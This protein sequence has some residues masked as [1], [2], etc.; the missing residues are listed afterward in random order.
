MGNQ[1]SSGIIKRR[2][3]PPQYRIQQKDH[4]RRIYWKVTDQNWMNEALFLLNL[5]ISRISSS[6]ITIPTTIGSLAV[7]IF[8][9]CLL[10]KHTIFFTFPLILF[11]ISS[12]LFVSLSPSH[13]HWRKWRSE[14]KDGERGPSSSS[15][16]FTQKR[17][18][19]MWCDDTHSVLGLGQTKENNYNAR[20]ER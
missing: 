12:F 2:L 15:D 18:R 19:W 16:S 4:V 20:R 13:Q 9:L 7:V 5:N 17:M 14:T 1:I 6:R 3:N 8:R 11:I 10:I